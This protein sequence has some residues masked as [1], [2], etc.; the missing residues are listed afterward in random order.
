VVRRF[1][2]LG[3]GDDYDDDSFFFAW[4]RAFCVLRDCVFFLLHIYYTE[5]YS[6]ICIGFFFSVFF[7]LF[8]FFYISSTFPSEKFFF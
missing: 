4:E 8:L 7:F 5:F 1:S 6:S 2:F 3:K